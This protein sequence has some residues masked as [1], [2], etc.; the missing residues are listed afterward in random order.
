MQVIINP[1]T[2]PVANSNLENATLN[3]EQFIKDSI[4]SRFERDEKEDYGEGR[5][6]FNV[7]SDDHPNHQ[8]NVQMPGLP[9]ENVRYLGLDSQNIWHFPRLYVDHSS[10]VWM[11]A[12]LTLEDWEPETE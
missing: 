11:Y 4:A 5:Y 2:G 3:M 7:F 9:L 12:T 8:I 1:G 6:S 10:W